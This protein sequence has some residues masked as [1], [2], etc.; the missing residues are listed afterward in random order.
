M[1]FSLTVT[2]PFGHQGILYE[3]AIE[4]ADSLQADKGCDEQAQ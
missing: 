2:S 3:P 1:I 4:E